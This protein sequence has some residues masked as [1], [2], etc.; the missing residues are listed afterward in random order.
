[1]VRYKFKKHLCSTLQQSSEYSQRDNLN[2][3]NSFARR[4]LPNNNVA[5]DESCS[6]TRESR[7][8]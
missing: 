8:I 4:L 7:P 2:E 6:C 5:E 3:N 1:V